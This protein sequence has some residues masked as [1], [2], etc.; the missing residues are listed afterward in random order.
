MPSSAARSAKAGKPLLEQVRLT[1]LERWWL[2]WFFDE[3]PQGRADMFQ[4]R[5]RIAFIHLVQADP[6]EMLSEQ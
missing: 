2:G 3:C 4:L 1:V 5:D 6:R